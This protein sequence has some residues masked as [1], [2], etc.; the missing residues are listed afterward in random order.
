MYSSSLDAT[1][2]QSYPHAAQPLHWTFPQFSRILGTNYS[3]FLQ[4][5]PCTFIQR[6]PMVLIDVKSLKF[7]KIPN[8][9]ESEIKV[10]SA[11]FPIY[12]KS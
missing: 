9:Y 12:F 3:K 8:D 7:H 11:N 1:H 10:I 4:I 5:K 2:L 6:N